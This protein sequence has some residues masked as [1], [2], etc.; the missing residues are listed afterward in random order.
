[1]CRDSYCVV[2]PIRYCIRLRVLVLNVL[3]EREPSA[4]SG[5]SLLPLRKRRYNSHAHEA[6]FAEGA[7][8]LWKIWFPGARQKQG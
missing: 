5:F 6:S 4:G 7:A 8:A 1:M 3:K 2:P